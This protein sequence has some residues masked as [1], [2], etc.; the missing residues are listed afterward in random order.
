MV[1]PANKHKYAEILGKPIY[2]QVV[3]SDYPR[4]EYEVILEIDGKEYTANIPLK[5][6][7]LYKENAIESMSK[8]LLNG[9]LKYTTHYYEVGQDGKKTC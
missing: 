5:S 2:R 9:V 6:V 4:T 8:M 1:V 7:R 3:L